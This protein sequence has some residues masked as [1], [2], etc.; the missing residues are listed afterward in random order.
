MNGSVTRMDRLELVGADPEAH[1]ETSH[2][3][4]QKRLE[5]GQPSTIPLS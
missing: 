3:G 1:E 2:I 5:Q 4:K